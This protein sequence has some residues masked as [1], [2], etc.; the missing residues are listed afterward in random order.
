M[1]SADL[2]WYEDREQ[3]AASLPPG[4]RRT[5]N[6]RLLVYVL[7]EN[8]LEFGFL[9]SPNVSGNVRRNDTD[10]SYRISFL[11]LFNTLLTGNTRGDDDY[12]MIFG[13][14]DGAIHSSLFH[15][16]SAEARGPVFIIT[17][18]KELED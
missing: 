15:S 10:G 2:V 6:D 14:N 1:I 9:N 4:H 13:E 17:S 7:D 3:L 12:Y 8:D 11:A 18:V 16:P 5:E